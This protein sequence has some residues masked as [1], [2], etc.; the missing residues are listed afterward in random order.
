ME[1]K[2]THD[3]TTALHYSPCIKYQAI[4]LLQLLML[5]S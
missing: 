1:R 2:R 3:H 5:K 4:N